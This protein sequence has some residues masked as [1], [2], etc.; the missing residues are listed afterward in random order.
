MTAEDRPDHRVLVE[1][2]D[3]VVTVT[4]NRPERLNALDIALRRRLAALW[5]E[6]R[7]DPSVR[8]VV[9]TGAGRAF[10]SGADITEAGLT[11]GATANLRY[12]PGEVLDVPVIVAMNGLC[13]G[14]ALRFLADA[15]IVVAAEDAW[16]SDPHVS[17]GQ[18]SAPVA[19]RLAVQASPAAVAPLMLCGSRYRMSAPEALRI[20]LVSEVVP[21]GQAV[22]RAREI[23]G[24]IA[25]QS[26]TAV[27]LTTTFL[28]RLRQRQIAGLDE[29]AW[30]AVIQQWAH[31]DVAEAR[32]AMAEGRAPRWSL[33]GDR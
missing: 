31:P 9:V 27:R 25:A 13:I 21:A 22:T 6:L 7:G 20:G 17:I 8:C 5:E 29:E 19:L 24:M 12:S 33:E 28:R 3:G 23:A 10:S 26:P 1:A 32:A 11:D 4:L 16:L 15:D 2:D 18:T 30:A 14:G